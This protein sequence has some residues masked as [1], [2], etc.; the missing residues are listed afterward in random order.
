MAEK[1]T[2]SEVEY[3]A[4]LA[5]LRLSPEVKEAFTHQLARILDYITKLNELD[6]SKI[7]PAFHI[8]P[9]TNVLREDEPGYSLPQDKALANAPQRVGEFFAVPKV[10]E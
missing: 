7:E 10:V 2:V 4:K 9:Q 1:I 8:L 3:V 5:K 6:T